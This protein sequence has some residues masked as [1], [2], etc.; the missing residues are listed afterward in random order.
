MKVLIITYYWPPSGGGGVQRWVKFVKYLPS[1]G[2]TPV[3]FHPENPDYPLI[4]QEMGKDLPSDLEYIKG[5]IFEPYKIFKLLSGKKKTENHGNILSKGKKVNFITKL[6]IWIRGNF[7]VPDARV[8]WRK[9]SVK[10]L[11]EYLKSNKI[12]AII[13]TGPPHS[14]HLI[15][16]D[17]KNTFGIKWIAD[18]RDAWSQIDYFEDLGLS[19][20][21]RKKHLNLEQNVLKSADKIITVGPNLANDLKKLYH[22]EIEVISNG[23][24]KDD[25][26]SINVNNS[27]SD[28]FIISH[29]GTLSYSQ[30]PFIFWEAISE[31]ISEDK[32][33]IEKVEIKLIG[34]IDPSVLKSISSLDLDKYIKTINYMPH[35]EAL[36]EQ[37][38]SDALLLSINN[39]P[40]NL[41]IVTG[42]I[43]EY[44]HVDKPIIGIGP[45]DGD[46]AA[47]IYETKS[48]KFFNYTQKAELKTYLFELLRG[49]NKQY[50]NKEKVNQYTREN[51]TKKLADLLSS[52]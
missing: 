17:L 25:Y 51:L 36:K 45:L 22:R 49:E 7:F 21:A 9:P 2:I 26:E 48:G 24:D 31:I 37:K 4:D 15:A 46:A 35:S 39:T 43:F 20:W 23:F 47:I 33:F 28:K 44:L 18:F 42:K 19:S 3:I 52:L 16:L 1:L 41:Q 38:L 14:S 12:D 8:F 5:K 13:S 6:S 27:K 32:S 34:K 50:I 30:N 40:N 29:I 10:I 11:E